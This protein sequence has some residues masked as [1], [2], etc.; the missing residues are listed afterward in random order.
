MG[1]ATSVPVGDKQSCPHCPS[2]DGYQMFSDGHGYCFSCKAYDPN[3]NE[4]NNQK[5]TKKREGLIDPG[6]FREI[7][8]R[9]ITKAT[10]E[11]FG[12]TIS[13]YK[14]EKVHVAPYYDRK[15]NLVAQHLRNADKDMPWVGKPNR[16]TL[17][18]QHLWADNGP[19]L[20]ITEGEID[21]L[22]VSQVLNHRHPV[23]SIPN[24]A[25]GA[26]NSIK[27]NI[28][29][30]ESFREVVLC[31]DN[32]EPGHQAVE[33]VSQ[34]ITP[35]KLRVVQ[36]PDRF[37]D[38]NE[39]LQAGEGKRLYDWIFKAPAYRP[40]GIIDG[41]DLYDDA[42]VEDPPG[43]EIPYPTLNKMFRGL[44]KGELYMFT[45]GSGIGKS[46]LVNEIGYHMLTEHKQRIG[47][48][49]LEDARRKTVK[50]YIGMHLNVPFVL[51]QHGKTKEEIDEAFRQTVGSGRFFLYDH[52]G[53]TGLDNL[54]NKFRYLAVGFK[55]DW[56]L[57]D[58]ISIVV[59]GLDEI[60][61]S[62][63]KMIDK[64]MTRLRSLVEETGVGILAV[65]HLSRPV[66]NNAKSYNEGRQVTLRSLRGSGALEQLSDGVIAMERNQQAEDPDVATLRVLKNRTIGET[67]IADTL[68]YIPE[69]GRL[70]T[71][72]QASFETTEEIYGF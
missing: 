45:A 47:V 6:D 46:T 3:P 25:Q 26:A 43:F 9:K 68:R 11:V 22:S 27:E 48:V 58:H 8:A 60:K 65:V 61:E 32:D 71:D 15:R 40:D 39:V 33:E 19:M 62:E 51:G 41:L 4:L 49:A 56:I 38:A 67:G 52:W 42:F 13:K 36:L 66:D 31:F 10:C 14:G 34:V 23:V 53:S 21:A 35:G 2:S 17:F 1:K 70:L 28:D 16:V 37:K 12:Y 63:R 50:K 64:L 5:K 29:F 7:K 30:V 57:L 59:S 20:I 69:T 24:G 44:R 54:I 18:G 55:V 72:E